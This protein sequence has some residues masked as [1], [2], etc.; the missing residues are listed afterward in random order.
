MRVLSVKFK[1]T[2]KSDILCSENPEVSKYICN[3]LKLNHCEKSL[4]QH[5]D[6]KMNAV[7]RASSIRGLVRTASEYVIEMLARKLGKENAVC[8]FLELKTSGSGFGYILCKIPLD[9][10][11]DKQLIEYLK[12]IGWLKEKHHRLE[13]KNYPCLSCSLF[14]TTG[15]KSIISIS[16]INDR[17]VGFMSPVPLLKDH[18]LKF[19]H[20]VI[21]KRK[22]LKPLKINAIASGNEFYVQVVVL[23][24][25]LRRLIAR[26][27]HMPE[28]VALATIWLALQLINLGFFRL[29][30]FK[31][32]GFGRV[33]FSFASEDDLKK[34]CKVLSCEENLE[35][36]TL[37]SITVLED[38]LKARL[39]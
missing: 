14:G 33:Y 22:Y 31:S 38:E 19:S 4:I 5:R 6:L 18:L 1:L 32:R 12:N 37:R 15:L 20:E 2:A 17:C 21:I 36:L 13:F 27:E 25:P 35:K 3:V 29:G 7:L 16:L 28:E 26:S 39:E 8:S 9:P 30:R 23:K 11:N 34:V 10:V 24:A